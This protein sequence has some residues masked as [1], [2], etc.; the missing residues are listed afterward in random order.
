MTKGKFTPQ[1]SGSSK[2]SGSLLMTIVVIAVVVIAALSSFYTVNANERG[3]VTRFGKFKATVEDGLHWKLPLGIDNVSK[4]PQTVQA[5]QF[6]FRTLQA[7]VSTTY[8]QSDWSHESE[9]LTGDLNIVDVTWIIEYRIIN[10][11]AWLF[12]VDSSRIARSRTEDNR[13]KTLRDVTQSAINQLVGDRAIL[14]ISSERVNIEYEAK[15]MI[16]DT[17]DSYNLGVSITEVKMQQVVPPKGEVQDAFED[18]NKAIQ[19]RNRLINEGEKAYYS[20][21][22]RI[23]GE[24]K[25]LIAEAEGYRQARINRAQ[26]DVALFNAIYQEYI[27]SPRVTRERMYYETLSEIFAESEKTDLIDKELDNFLPLKNLS[28]EGEATQ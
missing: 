9:M 17:L 23:K 16:Q 14:E 8:D 6:G 10:P 25:Q 20:E 24:A 19:D 22:P 12:N 28:N 7:G 3:V 1:D 13:D 2:V 26:A 18:V 15:Q 27:R 11:K 4:V 5:K 21:I